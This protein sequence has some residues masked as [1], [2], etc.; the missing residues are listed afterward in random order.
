MICSPSLTGESEAGRLACAYSGARLRAEL[1]ALS[2][3]VTALLAEW[4]ASGV[5]ARAELGSALR[6]PPPAEPRAL[7]ISRVVTERTY[8]RL[9]A[10]RTGADEESHL[11]RFLA[12]WH[13]DNHGADGGTGAR[14]GNRPLPSRPLALLAERG[15]T[16]CVLL[17]PRPSCTSPSPC[18]ARPHALHYPRC[19]EGEG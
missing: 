13:V 9:Q 4:E 18:R 5:A 16:H 17:P 14:Y 3:N 2:A 15:H 10:A 19:R 11:A 8:R 7:R 6:L 12:G 1:P